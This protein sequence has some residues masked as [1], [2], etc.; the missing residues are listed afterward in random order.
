M[1][2]ATALC[3][4][5]V[6]GCANM[7]K[8]C[9]DP[10]GEHF[11]TRPSPEEGQVSP[12]QRYFDDPLGKLPWDDVAVFLEPA[13]RVASIGSEVVLK[14]GV[15]GPDGHLRTNRRLEWTISQGSVGHFVAVEKNGLVDWMLL[16]FNWPRKVSDTHAIGST[17]RDFVRLNRGTPAPEDDVY[18]LRGQ[19]WVTVTSPVEGTTYVTVVAPEVYGWDE[20]IK[21]AAIHWVDAQWIL[22]PPAINPSGTKQV[23]TTTV[24]RQSSPSP[25]AGWLVRYEIA[26]GPPAGFLPDGTQAVEVPTNPM[27]QASVELAQKAPAHGTNRVNIQIIR[28]G[29]LPGANGRRLVIGSGSTMATWTAADLAVRICG[30]TSAALGSTLTYRIEVSNPGELAAK[31]VVVTQKIPA[32]L[33]FVSSN[34]VGQPAGQQLQWRLG[35]VGAHQQLVIDVSF[36]ADQQG[37]VTNCCDVTGADGLKAS[38]CITTTIGAT[39]AAPAIAPTTPQPG[40][41]TA[42]GPTSLEVKIT[43]AS[44]SAKV[45]DK[46]T[47]SIVV[48]NRGSTAATNLVIR[49]RFDAGMDPGVADAA[50]TR[51]LSRRLPDIAAGSS[52]QPFN[53]TFRVTQP[54][55]QCHTV[56]VSGPGMAVAKAQ[57]CVTASGGEMP[58]PPSNVPPKE[59]Q[60]SQ[61][62]VGGKSSLSA[63]LTGPKETLTVGEM[64]RFLIEIANTGSAAVRNV[65]VTVNLD[66]VL[67]PMSDSDMRATEGYRWDESSLVWTIDTLP[68]GK[69]AQIMILTKCQEPAAKAGCRV[70]AVAADGGQTSAETSFQIRV[71]GGPPAVTPP[72]TP[73]DTTASGELTMTIPGMH[74]PVLIGKGATY[75]IQITNN[76]TKKYRDVRLTATLPKGF[77]PD[78][79][80][81]QGP[82]GNTFQVEMQTGKIVFAPIMEVAPN[83]SLRYEVRGL[84]RQPVQGKFMAELTSPD[85]AKPVVREVAAEA[86]Q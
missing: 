32:G 43:P 36:R 29:E 84:A 75:Q 77:V 72:T 58:P 38:N 64:A 70:T 78:A 47:F 30:P 68:P 41:P 1:R 4:A 51:S 11:F 19:G 14:A 67:M 17:S 52:S 3:L 66:S 26:D 31:D 59:S 25:C 34:P 2:Y 56:E 50:A 28:P 22:P 57:A 9:I 27:G 53:L 6:C 83:Q 24:Q 39:A 81:T 23:L 18:V 20:R 54:G 86:V 85:L 44:T 80:R 82:G 73:Q 21:S 42:V 65:K 62:P 45:G 61:P 35:D 74:N 7:H 49:D 15:V 13:D 63:T 48:T 8:S 16:D 76:S 33:T 55:Q 60:P 71:A 37:S 40:A 79:L 12:N 10:T 46:V 69:P 5:V